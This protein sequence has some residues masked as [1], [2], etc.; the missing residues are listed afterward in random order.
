M[1]TY[2]KKEIIQECFRIWSED[3]DFIVK[4]SSN[5]VTI[6]VSQMYEYLSVNITHLMK[7][8]RFFNTSNIT[9]D[10][11]GER[12]CESCEYGSSYTVDITIEPGPPI[13]EILNED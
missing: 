11:Y 5:Q 10:R 6:S 12:G 9:D 1:K 4:V 13:E 3:E 7:L 2:T 8:M